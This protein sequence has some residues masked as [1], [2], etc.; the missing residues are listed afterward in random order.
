MPF[1]LSAP[2]L[3]DKQGGGA[4]SSRL[5]YFPENVLQWAGGGG[6]GPAASVLLQSNRQHSPPA[7]LHPRS[8]GLGSQPALPADVRLV[9]ALGAQVL[10]STGG[11]GAECPSP[12]PMHHALPLGL[13]AL[14]TWGLTCHL[15]SPGGRAL[16]GGLSTV[17]SSSRAASQLCP[18][19]LTALDFQQNC[20]P[21]RCPGHP[22][23]Q[24]RRADSVSG[25]RGEHTTLTGPQ[26]RS[27]RSSRWSSGCGLGS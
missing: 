13:E 18:L 22:V 4:A 3:R 5:F 20:P 25:P 26:S 7:A 24:C 15:A 16:W 23:T 12:R 17:C 2:H 8:G 11:G 9:G 19:Q 1:I 27:L 14:L 21:P 10:C 6:W